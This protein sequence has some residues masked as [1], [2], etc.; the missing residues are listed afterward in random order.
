MTA[1]APKTR[2][3]Q[4]PAPAADDGVLRLSTASAPA[5]EEAREPLFYIDDQPFTVPKLISPR[6]VYLGIDKMRRDGPLFGSMY[7]AELVLG[8]EQYQRL[9]KHYEDEDIDQDQFDQAIR[10]VSS[11]FFDQEK[12][13]A[14]QAEEEAGKASDASP[15]S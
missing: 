1:R 13:A 10:A 8:Q 2:T 12:R 6:I 7:V 9:L 4:V 11:L 3:A 15:A 14:S 5:V